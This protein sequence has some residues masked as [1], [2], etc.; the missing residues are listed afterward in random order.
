VAEVL[1]EVSTEEEGVSMEEE[2][3]EEDVLRVEE[4]DVPTVEEA[5]EE[6][7]GSTVEDEGEEEDVSTVREEEV[8]AFVFEGLDFLP[9][10]LAATEDRLTSATVAGGE[11]GCC[12]S[13]TGYS[14][15]MSWCG[16]LLSHRKQPCISALRD[17]SSSTWM[18]SI[19]LVPRVTLMLRGGVIWWK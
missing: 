4:E 11:A 13:M 7:E 19:V 3:E 9:F 16:S 10:F 14:A 6:E 18:H 15:C 5:D 2:E 17:C 1:A 8:V 12:S